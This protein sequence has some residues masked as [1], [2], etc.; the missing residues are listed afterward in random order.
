M[1]FGAKIKVKNLIISH[2]SPLRTD[3]EL[4]EIKLKYS[5]TNLL[6]ASENEKL[7]IYG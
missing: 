6:I 7:D 3:K 4:D 2:H 1:N 5:A